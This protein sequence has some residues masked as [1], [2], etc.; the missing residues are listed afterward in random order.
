MKKSTQISM[1]FFTLA[2]IL[3]LFSN[4]VTSN[5]L[6][7]FVGVFIVLGLAFS[8]YSF[9]EFVN[10]TGTTLFKNCTISKAT[11]VC[12]HYD[13]YYLSQDTQ[14][15]WVENSIFLRWQDNSPFKQ[16]LYG[17]AAAMGG[18]KNPHKNTHYYIFKLTQDSYVDVKT[19][20]TLLESSEI[21]VIE[22]GKASKYYAKETVLGMRVSIALGI[23]LILVLIAYIALQVR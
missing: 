4:R 6:R 19:L 7:L 16:A 5:D 2:L 21:E 9:K 17:F 22:T 3:E 18:L 14:Y 13:E 15:L 23:L 20:E 11:L 12:P 1:A 10:F 8:I